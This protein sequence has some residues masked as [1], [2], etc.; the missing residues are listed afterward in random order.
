MI[1]N[2]INEPS[3]T[4]SEALKR[5]SG[6]CVN[7]VLDEDLFDYEG[8]KSALA[9]GHESI[10][11]HMSFTFL[12]KDISRACSHQLVR[13]RLCSFSQ[14]SQRYS[15]VS[16]DDYL[17]Y[18]IPDSI[19]NNGNECISIYNK[20]MN[21][22]MK[23]YNKLMETYHIK[24][25]DA[26]YILPEATYTNIIFSCNAR[27]LIH[28]CQLR[29]CGKAQAEIRAL[30]FKIRNSIQQYPE[31]YNRCVPPCNGDA[32][33]CREKVKCKIPWSKYRYS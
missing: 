9:S 24:C 11:E 17:W 6:I 2:L 26:R 20:H 12:I 19:V 33:R 5:A 14:T 31:V 13:H 18:Y 32:R 1:V 30:F 25:E 28:M 23:L 21:E 4:E 22:C 3:I 7:K 16:N 8:Y 15:K 27:Q 10:L 29:L